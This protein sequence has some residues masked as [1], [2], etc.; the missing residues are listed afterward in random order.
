MNVPVSFVVSGVVEFISV[1]NVKYP[2]ANH[3]IN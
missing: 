3:R 1:I 2:K